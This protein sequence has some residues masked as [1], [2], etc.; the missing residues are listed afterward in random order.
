MTAA[1]HTLVWIDA[2]EAVIVRNPNGGFVF[3]HIDS[4]VP[5]H[6]RSTGHVRHDPTIRHGGGG[7]P[8]SAGESHRQEHLVRFRRRV[9]DRLPVADDLTIIGPGTVREHLEQEILEAD[10]RHHRGRVIVSESAERMT[11]RQLA[12]RLGRAA[13]TEPRRRIVGTTAGA[14]RGARA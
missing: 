12:A 6:R 13:G 3:E 1:G 8:Q 14:A 5:V 2:R 10:R 7:S 11:D 9:A 4:D